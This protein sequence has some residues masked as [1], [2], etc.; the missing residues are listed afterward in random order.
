MTLCV[1]VIDICID[2]NDEYYICI[3]LW[4]QT[5]LGKVIKAQSYYHFHMRASMFVLNDIGALWVVSV[6]WWA[7]ENINR[8][9]SATIYIN[10][11]FFTIAFVK[12]NFRRDVKVFNIGARFYKMSKA[13][14]FEQG[15]GLFIGKVYKI[16]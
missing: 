14:A 15:D 4:N 3:L 11:L 5:T 1:Y 16:C 12:F 2:V 13:C 10:I 8:Q 6:R 9:P 7:E